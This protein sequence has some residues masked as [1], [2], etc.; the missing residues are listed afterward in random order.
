MSFSKEAVVLAVGMVF[1][2][3]DLG[4]GKAVYRM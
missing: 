3:V 2:G 1:F 4:V